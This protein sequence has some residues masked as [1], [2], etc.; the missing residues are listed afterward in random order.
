MRPGAGG[1]APG[2]E[3]EPG[4]Q[5]HTLETVGEALLLCVAEAVA[6]EELVA[7]DETVADALAV[8][9]REA[10]E[11]EVALVVGEEVAVALAVAVA[12]A[13]GV[14]GPLASAAASAA[15]TARL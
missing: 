14:G 6:V 15:V 8:A 9:V 3:T 10:V 5:L 13:D 4:G 1:G 7:L 11:V 2:G 12:V